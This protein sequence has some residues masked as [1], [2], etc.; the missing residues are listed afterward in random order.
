MRGRMECETVETPVKSEELDGAAKFQEINWRAEA[1][2][3]GNYTYAI[4]LQD[5]LK[6]Y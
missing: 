5:D 4:A 3:R 6:R 1:D 2:E